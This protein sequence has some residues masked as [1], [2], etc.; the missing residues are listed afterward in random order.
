MAND[1]SRFARKF[2]N[3]FG[4]ANHFSG[5][6][7][8]MIYHDKVAVCFDTIKDTDLEL[9]LSWRNH[10]FIYQWCR[11]RDLINQ[12]DHY[13]WFK[14]LTNNKSIKMYLIRDITHLEPIGVCG[15]TDIDL[16]NQ[17][18]EFSLYIDPDK[19]RRGYGKDALKLLLHTG[20]KNYPFQIIYGETFHGNS[21]IKTFL[22]L[23]F[24]LEGTRRSFYFKNGQLIDADLV[25]I[26]RSE[27]DIDTTK[28]LKAL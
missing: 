14:S 19:Q 2:T 23:G 3:A 11:Q 13:A 5:R 12:Q 9:L 6:K 26:K 18:A 20:F 15:L 1:K 22:N 28:K 10:P 16:Y 21:V 7:T 8:K 27:F 17:R 25:S 24:H 4:R